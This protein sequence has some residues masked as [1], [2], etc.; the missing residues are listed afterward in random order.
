M[1]Y[2]ANLSIYRLRYCIQFKTKERYMPYIIKCFQFFFY[3]S[4]FIFSSI[5][6]AYSSEELTEIKQQN[7]IENIVKNIHQHSIYPDSALAV[8]A[9]LIDN[10]TNYKYLGYED[11]VAFAERITKDLRPITSDPLINVSFLQLHNKKVQ[12]T[13]LTNSVK[14]IEDNV[15]LVELNLASSNAEIDSLFAKLL[16]ADTLLLDL[17]DS[18]TSEFATIE[19]LSGYLFNQ[20]TLLTKVYWK[21]SEQLQEYWASEKVAG[22][23]RPDVPIYILTNGNTSG[24]AEIF[25][26]SLKQLKR[27]YIVGENTAGN[28]NPRR[29]FSIGNGLSISIPY[30][31]VKQPVQ[32]STYIKPDLLVV[33]FLAFQETYPMAKHSAVE[34]RVKQGRGTPQETY[35]INRDKITYPDWQFYKGSCLIKYRL[36]EPSYNETTQKYQFP[37]QVMYYGNDRVK[38]QYQLGNQRENLTQKISFGK[39]NTVRAGITQ[40]F[41]TH[42]KPSI[43]RCRI[44]S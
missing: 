33:S 30:G 41:L 40:G 5:S 14:I 23:K 21:D 9:K 42:N 3:S 11:R 29:D 15:G 1:Y 13:E 6:A 8:K 12:A 37:Y 18:D 38:M 43:L 34:Y 44:L 16:D 36:A 2:F 39:K 24:S 22:K 26:A 20:K 4:T 17:R 32:A 27:A 25:A 7:I 31:Q 28:M 35:S 10:F 19:Y